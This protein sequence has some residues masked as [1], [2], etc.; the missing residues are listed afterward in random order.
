M[1]IKKIPGDRLIEAAK[2]RIKFKDIFNMR[3]FYIALHE[4][5]LEYKWSSV[6]CDGKIEDKDHYETLYLERVGGK[7]E[8][9]MWWIWRLQKIPSK[10][11]YY[12]FHLDMDFHPLAIL[13]TEVIREGK[14]FKAVKGE[15]EVRLT[16][17]VEFD[18][19]GEW[20]N[21]PI[22]KIFNTVFPKRIFRQELYEDHKRELYREVYILQD[23]MKRWFKLKSFLPYEEI[24]PFY[25]SQ[26]YP[27][28]KKE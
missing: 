3:A 27:E 25:P 19:T 11:S 1:P 8:K 21:H 22:L 18:Y 12:K 6:D 15:V 7:G 14:K 4:W 17:Y 28:W 24:T 5:F 9:E 2:F 16:A 20:S 10:N 26:A 13:N 23:Y